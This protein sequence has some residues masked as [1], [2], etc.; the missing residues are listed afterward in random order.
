MCAVLSYQL[1]TG[2]ESPAAAPAGAPRALRVTAVYWLSE[3]G[4]KAALLAGQDGQARQALTIDV[5][6][7]RLHLVTVDARGV[8]RLKIQPRYERGAG[9]QIVRITG[10]PTY[11]SPPTVEELYAFAA[12]NYELER[13]YEAQSTAARTQRAEVE[14]E[15]RARITQMF[16]SDPAQRALPHPAPTPTR[17]FILAERRRLLFDVN[18]D[19]GFAHQLPPEAH[20]RFRADLRAR[21]E[22]NQETHTAQL[23]LHEEKRRAIATWISACGTPDQQARLAAGVLPFDEAIEAMTDHAFAGAT[24]YAR[25]ARDGAA[26]LQTYLRQHSGYEDALVTLGDLTIATAPAATAT[27]GQWGTLQKLRSAL[28]EA[29]VFLRAHRLAWRRDLRAPALTVHS[30]VAVQKA[31]LFTLRREYAAPD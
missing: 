25:Y 19:E 13:L 29:T 28:P 26:R 3:T 16:L 10:A 6:V 4:R 1:A 5:P 24:Q 15:L 21:R 22:R 12:R 14:R 23:A 27:Q 8:P 30:A 31:G 20:R 18:T 11:D 2:V 17:C 9:D 7:A